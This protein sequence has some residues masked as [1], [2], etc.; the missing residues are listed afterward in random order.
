MTRGH[1]PYSTEEPMLIRRIPHAAVAIAFLLLFAATAWA[2][3]SDRPVR[4]RAWQDRDRS[5][6]VQGLTMI[7]V[8]G[9]LSAP[10]GDFS[11]VYDAGWGLGASVAHG[12]SRVV[13]LSTAVSYHRFEHEVFSDV[14]ASITPWTFN[15]DVVLPTRSA[16]HPF[17]GGGIGLYHISESEDFGFGTVSFSENNFGINMG[18]G[19]GGPLSPRTLWGAGVRLHQVWGGDFIDT[20]FFTF[21]FGFGFEL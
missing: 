1:E 16:V 5:E 13:L 17:L 18:A 12:V 3:S 2:E 15:A 4:S 11:N 9:G 21:Q 6:G 19:I 20:P 8:H 7:R 10:I 14:H